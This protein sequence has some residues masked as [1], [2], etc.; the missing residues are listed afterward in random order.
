METVALEFGQTPLLMVH[1]KTFTPTPSV[2]N[3]DVAELGVVIIPTPDTNVHNA[4]PTAGV[5]PAIV[6]TV[7]HTV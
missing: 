7:A 3:P 6:A 2:V 5:L 1:W 4:V